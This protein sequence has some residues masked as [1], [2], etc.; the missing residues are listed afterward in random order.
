METPELVEPK[1]YAPGPGRPP[2]ASALPGR[3]DKDARPCR[4]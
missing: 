4:P 3:I 1:S 2:L